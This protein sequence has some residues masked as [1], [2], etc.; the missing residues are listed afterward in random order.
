MAAAVAA[1][2]VATTTSVATQETTPTRQA[3]V[4]VLTLATA[5]NLEQQDAD[6]ITSARFARSHP[7]ENYNVNKSKTD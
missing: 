3:F 1:A 4:G 6:F 5:A 7:T 2:V